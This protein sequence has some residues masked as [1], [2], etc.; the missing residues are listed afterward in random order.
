[1]STVTI[2]I[3]NWLDLIFATPLLIFRLL[4]YGY[5]F[6][7][8]PVGEGQFA[9]VDPKE[10]YWLNNFNWCIK[11]KD[12]C[13][14]AIRFLNVGKGKLRIIS[15]HRNIMDAPKGSIVDH[16]NNDGLDNRKSNLR[17]TTSSE[18][19][20]N[21]R[22]TLSKTSSRFTGVCLKKESGRW[23]ANIRVNKKKISLGYFDS[24]I[25][26]A[27]AYDCA[28]IKYFG[29]F[30]RLNFPEENRVSATR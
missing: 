2:K 11:K 12:R 17:F 26:A 8:I 28:A 27:K 29:K 21:R 5:A 1:M 22:K 7:R 9:I 16:R 4:R 15:M 6:R 30:A 14:Y 13:S 3:P 20:Q 18:N 25:E 24:E 23:Y 10:F 19:M